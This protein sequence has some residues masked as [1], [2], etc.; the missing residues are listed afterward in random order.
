[1]TAPDARRRATREALHCVAEHVVAAAQYAET[2]KIRLRY[3]SGGFETAVPLPG[4]RRIGVVDGQLVV[5]AGD[6][7]RRAALTTV[8][9]AAEFAGI[10]PGLPAAA[11]PP[12]TVLSADAPLRIDPLAARQFNDAY[13]LTDES[14]RA[15]AAECGRPDVEPVLWPE[16]FDL[17][18]TIDAINFGGLPG[19]DHIDE[20]YLY[21]GPHTVPTSDDPFWNASFGA[22]RPASAVRS[23]DDAVAFFR[24]GRALAAGEL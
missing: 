13:A 10:E 18:I 24:R 8:R 21:V 12:A 5:T 6:T 23:A 19:D 14:L 11:Y 3:V 15:F 4:G 2:G 20:P 16:H 22:A 7:V 9:A 17:A 1:M